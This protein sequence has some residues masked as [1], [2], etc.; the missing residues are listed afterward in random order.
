M[1]RIEKDSDGFL[2]DPSAWNKEVAD[3]LA[4]EFDTKLTK[5]HW[6]IVIYIRE[7]FDKYQKVPEL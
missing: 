3:S 5:E 6:L 4:Q 1:N 7:Y 2:I